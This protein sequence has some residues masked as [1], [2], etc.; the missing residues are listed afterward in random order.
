M[1]FTE[2]MKPINRPDKRDRTI[3]TD[4]Q[5]NPNLIA[6]PTGTELKVP[7]GWGI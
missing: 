6:H 3:D 7:Q 2:V 1:V 4:R 5:N